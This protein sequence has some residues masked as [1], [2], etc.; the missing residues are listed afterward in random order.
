MFPPTLSQA[1]TSL[2]S[3]SRFGRRSVGG[4]IS[5]GAVTTRSSLMGDEVGDLRELVLE[6]GNALEEL[7]KE[8]VGAE[9]RQKSSHQKLLGMMELL[10]ANLSPDISPSPR[11]F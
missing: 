10:L 9:A 8:A 2:A 11:V 6:Q 4:S 1:E 7:R 3:G 5:V